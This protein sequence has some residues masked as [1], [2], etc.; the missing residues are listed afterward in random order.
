MRIAARVLALVACAVVAASAPAA[1]MAKTLRVAFSSA[2]TG[3]DPQ[4]SY[5]VYSSD[6]CRAIFDALYTFDY[7]ARPVRLVPNTA[8][9]LPIVTDGGRTYTIKVK[10]GIY[11]A[12]DPAFKGKPRELTADDYVY[13]IKRII[14]PKVRSYW[15][16]LLEKNLVGLDPVLAKARETGTLDYA[17]AIEGLQVLD[18]YTL[19]IRFNR[20]DYAFQ[21]WLTSVQFAAVAREVVDAYKDASN[22][23]MDNPVGTGP[24]RAEGQGPRSAHRPR[25]QSQVSRRALSGARRRWRVG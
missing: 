11:F 1:D 15:L 14:D 16:Y 13:S 23:V 20:P 12:D 24:L 6:I 25:G 8:D 7:F 22:R 3:L 9:G 21:W 19:R 17:A 4:A 18:R 10:H 2:E 5:D